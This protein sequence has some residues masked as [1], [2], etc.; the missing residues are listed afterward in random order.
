MLTITFSLF[1]Y[2]TNRWNQIIPRSFDDQIDQLA[3]NVCISLCV[4]SAVPFTICYDVGYKIGKDCYRC[5]PEW[6][7]NIEEIEKTKEDVIPLRRSAR[8]AEKRAKK[9]L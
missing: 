9:L 8:L 6:E 2:I 4:I 1:D 3:A 7:E 5:K